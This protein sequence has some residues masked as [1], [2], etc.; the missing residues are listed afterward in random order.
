MTCTGSEGSL[1]QKL[2]ALSKIG[3]AISSDLFLEDIL[4]AGLQQLMA[5]PRKFA[6]QHIA[7]DDLCALTREAADVSGIPYVMETDKEEAARILAAS[8]RVHPRAGGCR[9][10]RVH[11]LGRMKGSRKALE[12]GFSTVRF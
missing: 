3:R 12:M 11:A 1:I 6:L 7:R 2:E 8:Q 5:G 10:R 9:F 4:N